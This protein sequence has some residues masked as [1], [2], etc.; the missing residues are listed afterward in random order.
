M[1]CNTFDQYCIL[2]KTKTSLTMFLDSSPRLIK[3]QG[4]TNRRMYGLRLTPAKPTFKA[5]FGGIGYQTCN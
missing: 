4:L 1:Y 5:G 3:L 2:E